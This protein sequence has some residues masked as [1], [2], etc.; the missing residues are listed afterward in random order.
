MP[1]E[2]VPPLLYY[3]SENMD[4]V[5]TNKEIYSYL[6]QQYKNQ[7]YLSAATEGA[8]LKRLDGLV[9]NLMTF[10]FLGERQLLVKSGKQELAFVDL[11]AEFSLRG[12]DIVPQLNASV[13]R[14]ENYRGHPNGSV[15]HDKLGALAG[16]KCLFKFTKL[17]FVDDLRRG[18]IRLTLASSYKKNGYNIAIRD[19]ELNI[20][21]QLRN[22]K[23]TLADGSE[24]PIKDDLIKRSAGGDYY[25]SC[26]SVALDPKL[27]HLFDV[28]ACFIIRN[29]D[30]F[31]KEVCRCYRE[32]YESSEIHFGRVDYIDPY[33]EFHTNKPI[34]FIKTFDFDY[35]K[36]FRFVAFDKNANYEEVRS[37]AVDMSK[38]K[39]DLVI[40]P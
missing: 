32:Q 11:L 29:G 35:E 22:L 15:I 16:E 7:R 12:L 21:H 9:T 2:F 34:E 27:F 20:H 30:A 5:C 18:Q 3:N 33:R 6:S 10:D 24:L 1:E 26:F 28:D 14:F 17:R 19:D 39:W 31:V 40:H 4:L 38:I 36:E 37:V 25:V 13:R 8:L 23:L